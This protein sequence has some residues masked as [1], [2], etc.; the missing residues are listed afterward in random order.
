[1]PRIAARTSPY[2]VVFDGQSLNLPDN[3]NYPAKV[4]A[5]YPGV[6]WVNVAIG[7]AS[8][9]ELY[10]GTGDA[11]GQPASTRTY[12]WGDRNFAIPIL[13]MCGGTADY[14]LF[15]DNDTAAQCYADQCQYADDARTAG[16]TYVTSSTTTP[17]SYITGTQETRRLAGNVLLIADASNKFDGVAQHAEHVDLDDSS[18]TTYYADGVHW[19]DAGGTVAAG[20]TKT[21]LDTIIV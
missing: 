6:A 13:V 21:V 11:V 5:N 9:T 4:M 10:N 12:V 1:M 17:A 3:G 8:W 20:I 18:V 16:F 2:F 15:G 14:N 7:G 19:T